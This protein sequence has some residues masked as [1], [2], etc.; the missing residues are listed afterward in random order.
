MLVSDYR[1]GKGVATAPIGAGVDGAA[2]DP[3]THDVFASNADGTLTVIHQ[4]APDTYRVTQTLKTL[5]GSRNVGLDPKTHALYL[6]GATFEPAQ[7]GAPRQRPK[8][9]PGVQRRM[10][11]CGR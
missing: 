6:A 10:T 3:S 2:F 4:D 11:Y 1:A 5:I 8:M 7:A 9:V